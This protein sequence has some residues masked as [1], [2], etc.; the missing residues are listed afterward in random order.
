MGVLRFKPRRQAEEI[1]GQ[2][3]AVFRQKRFG[4]E[5]HPVEQG[6]MAVGQSHDHPV[7]TA[8][9]DQQSIGGGLDHEGVVAGGPEGA[10]QT[11]K[12][13]GTLVEDLMT[14]TVDGFG[15]QHRL[16]PEDLIEGLHTQAHP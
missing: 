2:L 5:L 12:E 15:G 10:G 4:V 13:T 6:V 14:L 16:S 11:G 7:G 8:G 1:A 3:P 9:G